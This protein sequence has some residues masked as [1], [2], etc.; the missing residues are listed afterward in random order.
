[1]HYTFKIILTE[2]RLV[3]AMP[4]GQSKEESL[5]NEYRDEMGVMQMCGDQTEM[6]VT[7]HWEPP[8]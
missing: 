4:G 7:Q 6:V 3:V 5:V 2:S 8:K 1:M